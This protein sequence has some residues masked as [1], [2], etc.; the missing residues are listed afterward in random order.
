MS[1]LRLVNKERSHVVRACDTNFHI[2]SM[3][4]GE[5]ERLLIDITNIGAEQGAWERLL[6]VVCPV[7]TKIEGPDFEGKDAKS[8][9][10][11]LEDI[12]QMREFLQ[13]LIAHCSLTPD[14]RKT[15]SSSSEQPTPESAGSAEKRVD[16]DGELAS[17]TPTPKATL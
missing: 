4:V 8:I 2:I 15:S 7:I 10:S 13:Q 3:T 12:T 9:L 11:Q 14:E 5:K 16:P 17:I 1:G 6:N